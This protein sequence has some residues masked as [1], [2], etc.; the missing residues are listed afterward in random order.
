MCDNGTP[1]LCDQEEITVTVSEV[2]TAPVAV[3]DNYITP[4]NRVLN[5]LAP[6]VLTNDSDA[7][8]PANT[9]T[10]VLVTDI[11][12]GEG[13]LVLAS[14]VRCILPVDLAQLTYL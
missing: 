12:A 1:S 3:D 4:M 10:V 14:N 7:D 9:L 13:P 11:P 2:N 6:G 8:L 5:V